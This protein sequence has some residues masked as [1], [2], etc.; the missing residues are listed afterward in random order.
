MRILIALVA[1]MV[2]AQPVQAEDGK[3][4][5]FFKGTLHYSKKALV[6]PVYLL[7]GAAIGLGT[8]GVIWYHVGGSEN[9]IS[10]AFSGGS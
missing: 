4:K 9:E 2:L 8:G 5:R 1:V 7:G 6:L 3:L 10:K